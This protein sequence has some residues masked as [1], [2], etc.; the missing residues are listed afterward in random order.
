[1]SA[2]TDAPMNRAARSPSSIV[3]KSAELEKV[4]VT[5]EEYKKLA[6]TDPLTQIWNRR[7]FDQAIA[8]IYDSDKGRMFNA[9]ILADIDRFKDVNDRYGHPVGDRILQLVAD[10]I[11]HHCARGMFVARTGGE[12]FAIIADG[13]S[14]DGISRIAEADPPGD[15]DRA[16]RQQRIPARTTAPS[17]S[18]W[19]SAW[20]PRPTAPTTSTARPT[21]PSTPPRSAAATR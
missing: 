10:I 9:L 1:M 21:A 5:L 18:R 7:A 15:R 13:L 3:D 6:D 20:R 17:R 11:A 12:E 14:E 4:K 19:A 8:R 16:L 2:A